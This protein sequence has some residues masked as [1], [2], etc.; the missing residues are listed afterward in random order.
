MKHVLTIFTVMLVSVASAQTQEVPR[1]EYNFVIASNEVELV[2]GATKEIDFTILRSKQY[3]KSKAKLGLSSSLPQGLSISYE[4]SEGVIEH[5]KVM[6][7]ATQELAAGTYQ[8]IL[9]CTVNNK[10]KSAIVKITV[11]NST[12]KA[13]ISSNN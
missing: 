5:G 6:F 3:T 7:T 13:A 11:G 8:I 4:P 9:K 12:T 10:I 1:T 2:A